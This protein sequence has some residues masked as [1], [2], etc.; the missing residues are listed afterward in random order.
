MI[1]A[2]AIKNNHK[3]PFLY[4]TTYT[5]LSISYR[6]V[7][8][9]MGVCSLYDYVYKKIHGVHRTSTSYNPTEMFISIKVREMFIRYYMRFGHTR[10]EVEKKL[11][12]LGPKVHEDLSEYEIVVSNAFAIDFINH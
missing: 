6:D 8:K 12:I 9:G 11:S 7:R 10:E 5:K 2:N 1:S 3:Y 4:G